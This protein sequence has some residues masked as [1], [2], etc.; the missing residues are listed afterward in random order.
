MSG[1]LRELKNRIRSVESTKKITRAMEMVAAAK[2]HRFQGMM[3]SARPY[4]L[5]LE[6]Q[7]KRLFQA[8]GGASAEEAPHPFFEERAPKK[9][10]VVV[11]TSDT[12]LCGSYNTD[13]V[14]LTKRFLK[15]DLK[16]SEPVLIGIGKSG[17]TALQ[18]EGYDFAGTFT[19]LRASRV[20]EVLKGFKEMLEEL[21]V[22]RRVDAIHVVYDHFLTLST[23]QGVVERILP[24]EKPE[25]E[26]AGAE[27]P[28]IF[29]PDPAAIFS[30]IVPMFFEAKTRMILLEAL[31]SEQIARMQAMHLA[32][33]NA[34]E[35]I[36]SLVLLR[37][38]AR[39]AAITKEII[40]IVS[41]S[42]SL[43]IK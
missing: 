26:T 28:Y 13:L 43:K 39:Q 2:L 25:G 18:R 37:N 23:Y 15:N 10:A 40:E 32:T 4:T 9:T 42:S 1:Q 12:G 33:E 22:S 38:K 41:G 5:A 24:L 8:Q 6:N 3:N 17:I 20:E 36:D 21:Y 29:E 7:V 34:K 31:V 14:N 11:M 19:D 27:T 30:R 16:G 35:M